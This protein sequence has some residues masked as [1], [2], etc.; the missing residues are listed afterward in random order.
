MAAV[1]D[2]ID[3]DQ[4]DANGCRAGRQC[5]YFQQCKDNTSQM[6]NNA[7]VAWEERE[8]NNPQSNWWCRSCKLKH[9]RD[10]AET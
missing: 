5:R 3:P 8:D 2:H 10:L 9:T 1:G 6:S 7:P 4:S